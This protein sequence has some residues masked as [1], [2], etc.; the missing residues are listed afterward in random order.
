ME[1][2]SFNEKHWDMSLGTLMRLDSI[3]KKINYIKLTSRN[4]VVLA[5]TLE[6]LFG[7]Y[8]AYLK[9]DDEK[10]ATCM[11]NE[12]QKLVSEMENERNSK[13][14]TSSRKSTELWNMCLKFHYKSMR[15]LYD[16]DLLMR[17][18]QDTTDMI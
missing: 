10:K 16:Y 13:A 5:H 6:A 3:L 8:Y 9:K 15:Y 12:I 17:R 14:P 1:D 2:F 18:P 11:N 4:P 7:E